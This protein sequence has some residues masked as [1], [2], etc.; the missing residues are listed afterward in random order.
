MSIIV[1]NEPV[2]STIRRIIKSKGL[3]NS[4]VAERTSFSNQQFSNIL[5]GRKQLKACDIPQIAAALGVT[6]NDLFATR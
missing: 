3:K 2:S 1:N 6:P 5:C 4:A